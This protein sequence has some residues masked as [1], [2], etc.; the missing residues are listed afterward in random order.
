MS[1][2]GD[3][4]HRTG[5]YGATFCSRHEST[6]DSSPLYIYQSVILNLQDHQ[7]TPNNGVT[8]SL[9]RSSEAKVTLRGHK[10][11]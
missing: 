11:L 5:C 8:Y 9:T 4:Q 10:P 6:N 1:R 2:V 7:A 3:L